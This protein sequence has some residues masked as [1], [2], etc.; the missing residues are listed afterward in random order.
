[1]HSYL[2]LTFEECAPKL[3]FPQL[4]SKGAKG[5]EGGKGQVLPSQVHSTAGSD[6]NGQRRIEVG[7]PCVSRC[8]RTL[9]ALGS[10]GSLT[11]CFVAGAVQICQSLHWNHTSHPLCVLR[12]GQTMQ[13]WRSCQA[14]VSGLPC[15]SRCVSSE[16]SSLCLESR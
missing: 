2:M 13:I 11:N 6:A 8:P 10:K 9:A 4:Q 12:L 1:M 14:F 16:H 15:A 5:G 7:G 3:E